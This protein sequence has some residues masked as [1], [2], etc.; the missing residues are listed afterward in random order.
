MLRRILRPMAR[1]CGVAM[2]AGCST[3]SAPQHPVDKFGPAYAMAVIPV[4]N[5]SGSGF[6]D[7]THGETLA[8]GAAQGA[9]LGALAGGLVVGMGAIVFPPVGVPLGLALTPYLTAGGAIAGYAGATAIGSD[10]AS[11]VPAEQG[12]ILD[13]ALNDVLSDLRLPELTASA[14]VRSV[15]TFTPFRAEVTDGGVPASKDGLPSYRSLQDRG[16]DG[17]IEISITRIG[18]VGWGAD[19]ISLFVTAEAR[20][21]DTKT[22]NPTWLR[23]LVYESPTHSFSLWMREDAAVTRVELERAY[24]T[25]A[26]RIVDAFV[27]LT[28]P[29][30]SYGGGRSHT[31]G[32]ALLDPEPVL[33]RG[34]QNRQRLATPRVNSLTP[35]LAWSAVALAPRMSDSNPWATARDVRYDLRIWKAVEDAPGNMVYERPGLA[36]TR[37]EVE[38]ALEPATTYFWSVRMRGTVDG[39][40]RAVPWSLSRAPPVFSKPFLRQARFDAFVTGD[41]VKLHLCRLDSSIPCECL[42]YIPAENFYRFRTP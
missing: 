28:E 27:L 34:P 31:C 7:R 15:A 1:W 11:E 19:G 16:F 6:G 22:G 25:L 26:E 3:V 8:R 5:G 2:V 14:V 41:A 39:R 9:G 32:V 24:R 18:F 4:S 40:L 17:A 42:D 30:G 13:R 21:I 38:V 36:G 20:L 10:A 12:P 33:E 37:H 29:S 23:G 35:T